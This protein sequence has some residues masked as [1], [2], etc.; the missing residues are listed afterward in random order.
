MSSNHK[1]TLNVQNYCKYV[2]NFLIND[3]INW[4]KQLFLSCSNTFQLYC[5]FQDQVERSAFIFQMEAFFCLKLKIIRTEKSMNHK[6]FW[7]WFS[8]V[9]FLRGRLK[10]PRQQ[11]SIFT[12]C[13]RM[14]FSNPLGKMSKY[15]GFPTLARTFNSS[16]DTLWL[17]PHTL[18]PS[19]W[20]VRLY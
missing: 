4:Q 15:E 5:I 10:K 1:A 8:V 3:T 18:T 16:L 2:N 13:R 12:R 19:C 7:A 17:H 14:A 9:I 6:Y 20:A 11:K